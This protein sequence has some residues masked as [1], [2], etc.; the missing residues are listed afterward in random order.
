MKLRYQLYLFLFFLS[1][2]LFLVLGLNY[3]SY[4]NQYEKD[5]KN[6]INSEVRLHKKAILNSI[7]NRNSDFEGKKELFYNISKDALDLLK[8]DKNLNLSA[9]K[10]V[11][12]TKYDLKG[13]DFEIYLID[14][15]YKIYKTT[16]NKDLNL[17]LKN[18]SNAKNLL[19][20]SLDGNIHFSK[21]I[22]S[23]PVS[24]EYRLYS[25]S[26][27]SENDFL[28]LSFINTEISNT[29]MSSLI[30]NLQSNSSVKVYRV[31]KNKDGFSYYDLLKRL[32]SESKE[33]FYKS[34]NVVEREYISQNDIMNS[35]INFVQTE[36]LN[37]N[38][39]TITTPIFD[40]NMFEVL[41]FENVVIELKIDLSEKIEFMDEMENLFIGSL[42]VIFFLLLLIFIFIQNRFT[43][44]I[45]SI[46]K[47]IKDSKK[48]DEELL[49]Y[50]NELS[51]IAIKYNILYDNFKKELELNSNLLDENM[52]F[53]ADTVHQIRTPLTNIM[54]NGEMIKKFQKD[55]TMDTFI[56][57]ID[58]S[59]SMLS[60]SY[61]DLAYLVTSNSISYKP[62]NIELS[63]AIKDRIKFFTTISKVNFKKIESKLE[64]GIFVSIN[65]MELERIIDNNISNAIKYAF[66][67]KNI[68]I[69]LKKVN[70]FAILEFR[71]YGNE[72]KNKDKI[73]NKYYREDEAKRGLGLG[74]FMVGNICM[75]YD[76]KYEVLYKN[77]Q[78][79]F[80]YAFK[81]KNI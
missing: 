81:L 6:F 55:K 71:S 75:K 63:E 17:D 36:E 2:I 80:K 31:F 20:K 65:D 70:N 18:I 50:N 15:F 40:K 10:S 33:Q 51:K 43:I 3:I 49:L 48:V 73:F 58:A 25:Y 47:S 52:R 79:I 38:I 45:E 42:I 77:N 66:K 29:S 74:L 13:F 22:N 53:I 34:L 67:D 39:L 16:Y 35:A 14:N 62:K 69:I 56:E 37:E 44:P 21:F 32:E 9:L 61:E 72:I 23:D 59:I 54:M 76:I 11:L 27:I 26:S 60:N 1:A 46:L 30:Q 7:Q 19:D 64:E 8:K 24:L 12:K 28:E 57:Q 4:K 68:E 41:G 5:R 78:N